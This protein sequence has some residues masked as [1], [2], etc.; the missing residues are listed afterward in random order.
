MKHTIKEGHHYER[1]KLPR[2]IFNDVIRFKATFDENCLY[3][4]INKDSQDLNKLVG[5]SDDF[6]HM[7]NSIRVGWRCLNGIDIEL[8]AYAHVNSKI[9]STYLCSVKV[10]K[11]F[12]GTILIYDNV[13]MVDVII[14]NIMSSKTI[15][16]TSTFPNIRYKLNPYFGGNNVAPHDITLSLEIL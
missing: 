7:K 16:R 3:P 5:F 13:Y 8:Y 10:N 2:I 11:E 6:S 15:A 9:I 4:Q 14:D 12:T 1:F